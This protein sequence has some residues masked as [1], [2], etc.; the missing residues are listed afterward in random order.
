MTFDGRHSKKRIQTALSAWVR[1]W[2]RT[3]ELAIITDITKLFLI[4]SV[5]ILSWYFV[6]SYCYDLIACYTG[7]DFFGKLNIGSINRTVYDLCN[8]HYPNHLRSNIVFAALMFLRALPIFPAICYV[9]LLVL[10]HRLFFKRNVNLRKS[11]I[12]SLVVSLVFFVILSPYYF[13]VTYDFV[14]CLTDSDPLNKLGN[15]TVPCN[16]FLSKGHPR[17]YHE[18][19][20]VTLTMSDL[21]SGNYTNYFSINFYFITACISKTCIIGIFVCVS[22]LLVRVLYLLY[23]AF[24]RHLK[25]TVETYRHDIAKIV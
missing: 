16:K 10:Y 21:C 14:A 2:N 6:C 9:V 24:V 7:T 22:A 19:P 12:A 8:H 23:I 13:V 20:I 18:L 11:M 5:S 1:S 17:G 4:I 25:T 15:Y 3:P